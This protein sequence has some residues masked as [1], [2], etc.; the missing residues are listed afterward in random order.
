MLLVD[1][2]EVVDSAGRVDVPME[3]VGIGWGGW[4]RKVCGCV[5]LV[6]T[7]E[8]VLV[9]VSGRCLGGM[10]VAAVVGVFSLGHG[11]GW[12]GPFAFGFGG[13]HGR[14]NFLQF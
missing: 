5:W 7:E 9:T 13:K 6:A 10:L 3:L 2:T 4:R 11:R 14:R 8:R 1:L 12:D